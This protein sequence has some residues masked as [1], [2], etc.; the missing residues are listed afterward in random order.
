MGKRMKRVLG[1]AAAGMA[2][3]CFLVKTRTVDRPNMGWMREYDYAHRGL[4]DNEKGVPENS[5]LAF[6]E[7]VEQGYGI[8]L[9]VQMTRDGELAVIHD[10]TLNRL[11]GDSSQVEDLSLKDL[12]SYELFGTKERIPSLEEVLKFVDGRIP[13]I[14]ELKPVGE[15]IRQI[16]KRTAEVLDKYKGLFCV[17]SFDPRVL[18]WLKHNRPDWI[19]GQLT[20]YYIKH[21]NEEIEHMEDFCLHHSLFNVVTRPDYL[22]YNT[23]DRECLTLRLCR[24]LFDAVEVDWTIRDREQYELVKHDGAVVIFEG[25]QP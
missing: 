25:F 12:Q 8:E 21:G 15:N 13:L 17:Q 6:G 20:E 10:Y 5:L 9:D 22:A 24:K 18:I 3:F 14:I 16:A 23:E 1:Y 7:A 4:Y 19:R 2:F 11:C